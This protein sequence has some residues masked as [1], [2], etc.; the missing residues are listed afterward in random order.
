FAAGDLDRRALTE[1]GEQPSGVLLWRLI[2]PDLRPIEL[3]EVHAHIWALPREPRDRDGAAAGNPD[4]RRL[5][6]RPGQIANSATGPQ[7][8]AERARS[9]RVDPDTAARAKHLHRTVKRPPDPRP[10]LDRD[11]AQ[12]GK[13]GTQRL[14]LPPP[15]LH[16][17]PD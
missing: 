17:P 6:H 2:A 9:L 10:T 3:E 13:V 14:V 11:L 5:R 7:R 15:G 16:Q 8:P 12:P 4:D 1:L